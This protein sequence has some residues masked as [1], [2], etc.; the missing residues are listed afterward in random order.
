MSVAV[1]G[2]RGRLLPFWRNYAIISDDA[3]V[4]IVL[5]LG[6]LVGVCWH[7]A[8]KYLLLKT[9]WVSRSHARMATF[10]SGH[11]VQLSSK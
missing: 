3:I 8:R 11:Y 1:R 6:T 10:L 2:A 4:K 7:W 9:L 5:D